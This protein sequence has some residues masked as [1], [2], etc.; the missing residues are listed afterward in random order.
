MKIKFENVGS[1]RAAWVAEITPTDPDDSDAIQ[2]AIAKEAIK[3]GGLPQRFIC[4]VLDDDLNGGSIYHGDY[5][6]GGFEIL[7]D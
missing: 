4:A 2:D 7:A 6:A 3:N 5:F 1:R